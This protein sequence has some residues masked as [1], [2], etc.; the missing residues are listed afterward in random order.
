MT[1]TPTGSGWY[2]Y[3]TAYN[4]SLFP[5]W[6]AC[7]TRGDEVKALQRAINHCYNSIA[8]LVVDGIYGDTPRAAE[9][10]VQTTH[11]ITV[12]GEYGPHAYE[13]MISRRI[14]RST[15]GSPAPAS[16]PFLMAHGGLGGSRGWAGQDAPMVRRHELTD[17]QCGRSNP[18]S[19]ETTGRASSGRITT[20]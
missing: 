4:S 8:N 2:V 16:R 11:G 18:S 15:M 7:G 9:R 12:D 17:A 6:M 5:C 20:W 13:A 19:P 10:I 14:G 1:S 3:L